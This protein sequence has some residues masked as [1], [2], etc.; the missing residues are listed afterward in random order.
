MVISHNVTARGLN[1]IKHFEG[2]FLKAYRCE[3]RV[4]TIGYGHTGL[5][6]QDG[7]VYEGRVITEAEAL[8]LLDY[9]LNQFEAR[10]RALVKV[11][12]SA[13]Q[14]EALVSFDFNTGALHRSTVLKRLNA[15]DYQGAA[16]ALLMW[17]RA[18]G[19]IQPGLV[20][21]RKAERH[22]FLTG[23]IKFNF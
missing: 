10:V 20:R 4:W 2:L 15:G 8:E 11:P 14:F 1:L 18:G 12:L 9:D 16:D 7:T 13:A 6:H 21:R 5:Q 3:G 17:K 23:E 22:L 19:K